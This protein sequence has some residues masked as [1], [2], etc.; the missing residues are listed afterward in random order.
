MIAEK[1]AKPAVTILIQPFKDIKPET[2]VKVAEGIRNIYQ[3]VKVLDA[4]E[5]PENTY[6]KERNRYR[7]DS[8]IKF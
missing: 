8:I 6:Y 2:V 4:I 1:A 7:A 3:N 5:F